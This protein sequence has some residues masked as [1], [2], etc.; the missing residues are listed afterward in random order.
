MNANNPLHAP[1]FTPLPLGQVR[2]QGWLARQLRI[3][4]EGLSGH[5]DEF[6]PDIQESRWFGGDAEGWERAP[7]WLDGVIPLAFLLDDKVLKAKVTRYVNYI[8]THQHE[9]G[10]L[11]PRTMAGTGGGWESDRYDLWA[12]FLALKMLTQ[13]HDAT[14]DTR[15]IKAVEKCLHRIDRHID[16]APL[17]NWAQFRWFEAL[18]PIYWLYEHTGESWLLD[19]SVKLHAQGFNWR[20]FFERWPLTKSTPKGRWSYM[21]H[22]VN[23]AMAIKAH[24]LWWRQSGDKQD[25]AAVYDMIAK[26]DRYHGMV[27]GVFT[28]DECIAGLDPIQ[29]TELCAV[30]EYMY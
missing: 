18:I 28:G 12:L 20:A 4:A 11:G 15:V 1:P 27:T 25:R 19:L 16:R 17:F 10:W 22:V 7:Y 5:L 2:P 24:G 30:V 26:L 21:S 9:D 8:L 13:Y 29:G 23:N 14:S 6:W 3:Q